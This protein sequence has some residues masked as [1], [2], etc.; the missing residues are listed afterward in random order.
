MGQCL[1]YCQSDSL[2]TRLSSS[3]NSSNQ[4]NEFLLLTK[5]I[6]STD[7]TPS[8]DLAVSSR[9]ESVE[10]RWWGGGAP[11]GRPRDARPSSM[12]ASHRVR[13]GLGQAYQL[14]PSA[15]WQNPEHSKYHIIPEKHK[16]DVSTK[17]ASD[18]GLNKI[19]LASD[20]RLIS[21]AHLLPL[22]LTSSARLF[23]LFFARWVALGSIGNSEF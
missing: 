21:G 5:H 22:V 15:K 17:N 7:T 13:C 18:W 8:S 9:P 12:H 6:T 19:R 1:P 10:C 16:P 20:R 3:Y 23:P 2:H 11:R 4:T 14:S